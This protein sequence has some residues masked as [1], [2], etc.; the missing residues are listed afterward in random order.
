[1]MVFDL[2]FGLVLPTLCFALRESGHPTATELVLMGIADGSFG[3]G[4]L[5]SARCAA[6][7]L[8]P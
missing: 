8:Q 5:V 7:A 3:S 1:M 6:I 4:R 2:I